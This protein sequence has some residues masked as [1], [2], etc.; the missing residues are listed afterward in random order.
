MSLLAWLARSVADRD[1]P[2]HPT[3]LLAD[4]PPSLFLKGERDPDGFKF[5]SLHVEDASQELSEFD[6]MR[7]IL[8]ERNKAIATIECH[9]AF[10][11]SPV[12]IDNFAARLGE[13]PGAEAE[14]A[15]GDSAAALA[16]GH[17]VTEEPQFH[18]QGHKYMSSGTLEEPEVGAAEFERW[19][20]LQRELHD[21]MLAWAPRA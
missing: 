5:V 21:H 19:L 10:M 12:L 1:P 6:P 9:I 11:G 4:L 14:V 18:F 20:R 8:I 3:L 7:A 2:R 16:I 15:L 13:L 17:L